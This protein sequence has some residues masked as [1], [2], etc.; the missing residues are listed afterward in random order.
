MNYSTT[1]SYRLPAPNS[2]GE[3]E[4]EIECSIEW[5]GSR[6]TPPVTSGP[7]DAWDPGDPGYFEV[8]NIT[9]EDDY[10]ELK[11]KKGDTIRLDQVIETESQLEEMIMCD[12]EDEGP[13][14]DDYDDFDYD[15][16]AH[17]YIYE[18]PGW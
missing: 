18:G 12:V 11:L 7:P 17:D 6:G 3:T 9:V 10:P 16:P 5:D 13:D 1:L 8:T 2:D 14:Y 4:A 15:D